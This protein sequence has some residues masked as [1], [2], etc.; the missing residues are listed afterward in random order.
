MA[1]IVMSLLALTNDE[2]CIVT[3]S[4]VESFVREADGQ[5]CGLNESQGHCKLLLRALLLNRLA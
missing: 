1:R 3:S 5:L 4:Y 2:L